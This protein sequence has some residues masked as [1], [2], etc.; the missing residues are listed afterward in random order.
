MKILILDTHIYI[1]PV[2]NNIYTHIKVENQSLVKYWK[3]L[4]INILCYYQ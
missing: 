3:T 1:Y 2:F 4:S